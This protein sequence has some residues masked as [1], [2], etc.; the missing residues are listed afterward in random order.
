M[1]KEAQC[2][3]IPEGPQRDKEI[4]KT[5]S[6]ALQ[7]RDSDMDTDSSLDLDVREA[8]HPSYDALAPLQED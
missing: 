5:C 8:A 1:D 7:V 6:T 4:V 2:C 3:A